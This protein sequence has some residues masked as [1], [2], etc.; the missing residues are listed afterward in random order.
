MKTN[1]L[2]DE[3]YFHTQ[4]FRMLNEDKYIT[5]TKN[6]KQ[7]KNYASIKNVHMALT[8][9]CLASTSCVQPIWLASMKVT[10]SALFG[11]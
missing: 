6:L 9:L 7:V 8:K 5:S 11:K 10:H 2:T 4:V 1:S 3:M